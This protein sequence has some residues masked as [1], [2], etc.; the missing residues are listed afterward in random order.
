MANAVHKAFP[1]ILH[2][3]DIAAG[4]GLLAWIL[5][6]LARTGETPLPRTAVAVDI[7][8]PKSANALA[9]SITE[10][11]PDLADSVHYVEGSIDAVIAEGG[12]GTLLVAAHACGSLSDRVLMAAIK[13]KSPVA[14]MPCCHSLRK[15]AQSLSSLAL[16]SGMP[17]HSI[18]H[19]FSAKTA[20][21]Q[22]ALIDQFRCDA[23][24]V[25]GYQIVE[26]SIQA[27]ITA[28]NRIIMG[29]AP[30][31]IHGNAA[32]IYPDFGG[33]GLCKRPGE[34]RA[35]EKLRT[36]NVANIKEA[37]ALS[38]RPSREWL[39]SFD[40]SYWVDADS[41][42]QLIAAALAFLSQRI[43]LSQ[44]SESREETAEETH[45][46]ATAVLG[47][48]RSGDAATPE[49]VDSAIVASITILDCY[50]DPTTRQSAFTYRIEIRSSTVSITKADAA[51]LRR[52]LCRTLRSLSQMLP[53]NF[54]LRGE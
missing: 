47:Y 54:A 37:Q 38:K 16:A 34:T 52:K 24:A 7:N 32:S 39:R 29:I 10:R 27:E 31:T 48:L 49:P 4:H 40:L 2:V 44:L 46:D 33:Q 25:L 3:A 15:Q 21:G 45:K 53:A 17:S 13:S 18:D 20:V 1:E 6:L 22:P 42:G 51:L 35:Y 30:S 28:F 43:F 5:V 19:I 14:I 41:T 36:L 50:T 26:D 8:R 9:A 23:L 12:P 11:W